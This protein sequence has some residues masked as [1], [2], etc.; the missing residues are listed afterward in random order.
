MPTPNGFPMTCQSSRGDRIQIVG[1]YNGFLYLWESV[2]HALC[3]LTF[4]NL[5]VSNF[6]HETR[7]R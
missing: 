2:Y 4:W 6:D 3:F 5:V 1:K 7:Q